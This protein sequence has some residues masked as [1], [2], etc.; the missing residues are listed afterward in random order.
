[1]TPA[2]TVPP[3][4]FDVAVVGAGVVGLAHAWHAV[5]AGLRVVVLERDEFAVGASIRN[6][7]HICTTAQSGLV[8]EYALRAREEWLTIGA[9]A[10]IP[11]AAHGTAVIARRPEELAVLEEFVGERSDDNVLLTPAQLA[12]R[13]GFDAP[14]ALGGAWLSL[15]LRVDSPTAIP[16]FAAHLAGRGVEFRYRSNVLAVESDRVVTTAGDVA[17]D[18]VIVAVGH[19]VDRFFPALA[20]EHGVVRCRLRMIEA[21]APAGIT[22]D[23][24]VFTGTSLL[25][26]DGFAET[27]SAEALRDALARE[28][29]ALGEHGVNLM[30]TQR[31]SHSGAAGRL[32][33]GDTHHYSLTETPFE[34][35]AS[36]E[37]LLAEFRELLGADHLVV[38]RRWRGVYASSPRGPYLVAS[39]A[40]GVTAVSVTSGIGMTTALGLAASVLDL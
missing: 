33:L 11:V 32:V 24:G 17:A 29:P 1:M 21:D 27:K 18:R 3:A 25:R 30:F 35:E 39:P 20:E 14:G 34:D 6:F 23:P 40:P 12:D 31:L 15:D 19:D 7:G 38:R 10:G 5:R 37:L 8:Y 16:A 28:A 36:D 9:D 4:R 13:L 26:Y 2:P 22:V